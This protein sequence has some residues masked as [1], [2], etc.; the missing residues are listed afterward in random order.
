[1]DGTLMEIGPY[2]VKEDQSLEENPGSWH[3]FA[4]LLFV[5]QPVGTGFS[6]VDSNHYLTDLDQVRYVLILEMGVKANFISDGGSFHQVF[7]EMVCIV[8]R[9]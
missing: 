3:E 9:V 2:R 5:D 6:Y 8:S 1:M 7:R 4:N